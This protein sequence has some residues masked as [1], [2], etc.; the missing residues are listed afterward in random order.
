MLLHNLRQKIIQSN[1]SAAKM[2]KEAIFIFYYKPDIY[3][4]KLHQWREQVNRQSKYL[5]LYD[6]SVIF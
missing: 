5:F 4:V 1:E 6:I 3:A 2:V